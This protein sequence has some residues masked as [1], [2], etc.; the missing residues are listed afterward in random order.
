M[1]RTHVSVT[2]SVVSW[3]RHVGD[4]IHL[5][6]SV[7]N[8]ILS[9]YCALNF[10]ILVKSQLGLVIVVGKGTS[11]GSEPAC[12]PI[13]RPKKWRTSR[14]LTS[15]LA[16]LNEVYGDS[17]RSNYSETWNACRI[18]VQISICVIMWLY[19]HRKA[20]KCVFYQNGGDFHYISCRNLQS[21]SIFE[22]TVWECN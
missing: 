8:V 3:S 1:S 7:R 2:R 13:R 11:L 6:T 14:D 5:L 17:K 12:A 18:A 21:W 10:A 22:E 4:S 9:R 19:D 20:R 15:S 16:N